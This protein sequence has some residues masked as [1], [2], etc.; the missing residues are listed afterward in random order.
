M[1]NVKRRGKNDKK[2]TIAWVRNEVEQYLAVGKWALQVA[3][4]ITFFSQMK[5]TKE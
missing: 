3:Y 1:Q 4:T 2:R 5:T